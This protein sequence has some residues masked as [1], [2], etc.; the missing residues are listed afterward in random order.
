MTLS[1]VAGSTAWALVLLR[2]RMGSPTRRRKKPTTSTDLRRHHALVFNPS[3][4][5][6]YWIF[7]FFFPLPPSVLQPHPRWTDGE[8]DHSSLKKKKSSAIAPGPFSKTNKYSEYCGDFRAHHSSWTFYSF[9][10]QH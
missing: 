1:T 5:S 10:L 8:H 7:F 4:Q 3:E 6:K 2:L 9:V